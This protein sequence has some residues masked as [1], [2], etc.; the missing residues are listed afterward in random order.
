MRAAD[1][2]LRHRNFRALFAGHTVNYLGNGIAPVALAFAVLDLGGSAT[3]LGLVIGLYA[4]ADVA[5]VLFGGVLGDRVSRRTMMQC[6]TAAAALVQGV[7]AAALVGGWA[8]L[9]LL[10]GTGMLIGALGA[11][12]L[13]SSSAITRQT[14]PDSL[15]QQAISVRRL[16]QNVAWMV[17][18]GLAGLMVVTVGSGWAL[19]LDAATFALAAAAFSA[20]RVPALPAPESAGLLAD[21]GA[22][23]REVLRHT[24]LWLLILQALLYHLFYG[25]AQGVLGPIVVGDGLG[26]AAW[27]YA[28][29]VMLAGFV[30]GGLVTLWWRPRRPL[31]AGTWLLGLTAG[32]PAAMAWSDSLTVVLLGAFLH[33]FGLEIFSVGWDLSIQQNVAPDKLARVYSFDNVGSFIARPVG[34]ALTGPV[35]TAVGLHAW[36][37]VIAA[38]IV[39]SVALALASPAVRR[40]ER[41]AVPQPMSS[42]AEPGLTSHG[43]H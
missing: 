26:R 19:A 11:L 29:S 27:G 35:A 20:I 39:G 6:S 38:V 3:E 17:G 4:L 30:V 24:W 34:L 1:H 21:A 40:L 33:G 13:P 8:S 22:G 5:A 31:Y 43:A 16:G 7:A 28:L 12:G 32:F 37:G 18:A 25:G 9:P 41:R 14:I 2:V 36:L 42:A 10:A 23:L 15:L